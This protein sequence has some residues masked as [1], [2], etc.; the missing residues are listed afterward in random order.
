MISDLDEHHGAD[1]NIE[2]AGVKEGYDHDVYDFEI[3]F[4]WMVKTPFSL[5]LLYYQ[6]FFF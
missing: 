5:T 1:I 3:F 4:F 2:A 6:L